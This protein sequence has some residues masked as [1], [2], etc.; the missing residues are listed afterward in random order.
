MA[1]L[2]HTIKLANYRCFGMGPPAEIRFGDGIT[3]VV[4]AN[5]AGKSALLRSIHDLRGLF[6][7]CAALNG[8]FS[9]DRPVPARSGSG[10]TGP[11]ADSIFC[12]R[13]DGP[14]TVECAVEGP[15]QRPA[16]VKFEI[17]RTQ[18]LT[19]QR[20]DLRGPTPSPALHGAFQR[21]TRS[22]YI[23]A[24]RHCLSSPGAGLFDMKVGMAFVETWNE[25]QAGNDRSKSVLIQKVTADATRLLGL[26]SLQI[27][28]SAGAG[29]LHLTLEGKPYKLEEV[30]GGVAQM[31]MLL[32][33]VA[34]DKPEFLFIDEPEL[35]LHPALQL[36]VLTTLESYTR[37]GLV[38]ATHNLGLARA[39]ASRIY[40]VRR[41]ED[42]L[43]T[44]HEYQATPELPELLGSLQYG[45]QSQV[46]CE[47]VL[48][49]EG[50]HDVPVMQ[51]F[52][53]LLGAEHRVV[54]LPLGGGAL[55]C[56]TV[57]H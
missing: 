11:D 25:A 39:L 23:P 43:S 40:A 7:G 13:T 47:R 33:T 53:R 57:E 2:L 19:A 36:D 30:G 22:M 45:A 4:G 10:P 46:G 44:V 15:G 49:V 20:V 17:P 3:A 42:G 1:G 29:T 18:P 24:F 48:L 14:M 28:K 32:G 12:D 35:N 5:N 21:L 8:N 16:M 41:G 38:Y 34:L 52:C 26:R 37:S 55:I 27:Q 56:G 31:L 50:V 54:F 9:A 51:Q 6:E